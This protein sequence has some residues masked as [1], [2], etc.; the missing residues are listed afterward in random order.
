MNK[1][2]NRYMK[3][4]ILI[5]YSSKGGWFIIIGSMASNYYEYN[6][7]W[8][9]LDIDDGVSLIYMEFKN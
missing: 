4:D 3:Y 6:I 1:I 2:I 8:L 5:V 9:K 7:V